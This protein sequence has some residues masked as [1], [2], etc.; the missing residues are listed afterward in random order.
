MCEGERSQ[1]QRERDRL[2]RSGAGRGKQRPEYEGTEEDDVLTQAI[3]R[4]G[5]AKLCARRGKLDEAEAVAREGVAL[6][7]TTEFVDLRGD[8]LLALAEV[9][10]LGG[11]ADEAADATRQAL[12]IWEAKGNVVQA[13]RARALLARGS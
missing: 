4:A 7:E 9:L 6:A 11:R 10:R 2:A 8:G 12:A 13:E 3:V 5:R 1:P